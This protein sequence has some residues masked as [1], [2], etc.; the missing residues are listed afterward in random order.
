MNGTL[1]S[2][3]CSLPHAAA[4]KSSDYHRS[5]AVV[6]QLPCPKSPLKRLSGPETNRPPPKEGT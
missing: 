3:R 2:E 5:A 6:A 1:V 4:E